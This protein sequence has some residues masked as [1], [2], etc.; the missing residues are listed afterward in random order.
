MKQK[1]T[2]R[3]ELP[4]YT[5]RAVD[6]TPDG[7]L[8]AMA[9][10]D[11]W[12][13]NY[14]RGG[15]KGSAYL[16]VWDLE[17]GVERFRLVRNRKTYFTAFSLVTVSADGRLVA[18]ASERDQ[19][20]VWDGMTGELLQRF[21]AGSV[22]AALEFSEDGGRLASGQRDG[23]VLVWDTRGAVERTRP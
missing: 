4:A 21:D 23:S 16:N 22:V 9:V 18:T 8:L 14:D 2:H 1:E 20:E 15:T 6:G 19:I 7:K 11:D 13:L 5:Q 10:A 3:F 17:R 12:T